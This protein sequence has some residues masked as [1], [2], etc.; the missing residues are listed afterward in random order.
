M[1]RKR[2]TLRWK[3]ELDSYIPKGGEVI[4]SFSTS[5]ANTK[6]II[7]PVLSLNSGLFEN[8]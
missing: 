5:V 2:R 7:R 8:A 4:A 1:D 6:Q 3:T